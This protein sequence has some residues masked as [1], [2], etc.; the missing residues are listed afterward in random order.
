MLLPP[1]LDELIE[2]ER[3]AESADARAPASIEGTAIDLEEGLYVSAVRLE[4]KTSIRK[5]AST[6]FVRA[7]WWKLSSS[8]R[9]PTMQAPAIT[10]PLRR[11]ACN[12]WKDSAY[13]IRV[14]HERG[15]EEG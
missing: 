11:R 2:P 3:V 12:A 15:G 8:Q 6:P 4:G 1:K 5:T 9:T 14:Q 7:T 10:S 13:R